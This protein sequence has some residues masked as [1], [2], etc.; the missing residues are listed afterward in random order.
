MSHFW[1]A[2]RAR[3]AAWGRPAGAVIALCMLQGPAAANLLVNG[4][5]EAPIVTP[6]SFQNFG[7][8]S[9]LITGWTVVGVDS[10]VVSDTFVQSGITF[11]A[12]E[13]SQW[14]DLAGVTSN[15]MLSGVTQ[16]VATV[17]GASYELS[18]YVGGT[19]DASLFFP[20]TIDVSVD[21]SARTSFANTATPRN[22]V[23]WQLFT[24][25]FVAA[26]PTTALTFFNGSGPGNFF[27]GLDDVSLNAVS[28][29]T[30]VPEPAEWAL[31]TG[32]LAFIAARRRRAS[33]RTPC[34]AT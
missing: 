7:A 27:N 22:S 23:D 11:N 9:T 25:G 24:V 15:S 14:L 33:S 19:S 16:T 18:F 17:A 26:A 5:F 3:G 32:G 4:S 12:S 10:A 29:T 28:V 1:N 2:T 21:G 31:I 30:P 34:S 20:A 8:G 13:G 6:G